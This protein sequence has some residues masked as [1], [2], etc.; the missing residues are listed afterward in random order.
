M[1]FSDS[2]LCNEPQPLTSTRRIKGDLL[3]NFYAGLICYTVTV[4]EPQLSQRV[5]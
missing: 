3:Q 1:Y 4:R 5:A 2:A